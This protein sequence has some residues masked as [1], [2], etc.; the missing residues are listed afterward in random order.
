MDSNLQY[1]AQIASRF[2]ASSRWVKTAAA[3]AA[4]AFLALAEEAPKL[5]RLARRQIQTHP[6][7]APSRGG[8]P[9]P[10]GRMRM[11]TASTRSSWSRHNGRAI[12]CRP[13][14]TSTGASRVFKPPAHDNSKS[15]QP[16]KC[17][18]ERERR[19]LCHR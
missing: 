1:R 9:Q 15:R 6:C 19:G 13:E 11:F 14:G 17:D 12:R 3:P 4:Y 16:K 8:D 10:T 7:A 2:E 5:R 18:C